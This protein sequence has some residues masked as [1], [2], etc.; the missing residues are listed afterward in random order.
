MSDLTAS[1]LLLILVGAFGWAIFRV[2]TTLE[3]G[4]PSSKRADY[5]SLGG[6]APEDDR[7]LQE[8]I[9]V[10]ARYASTDDLK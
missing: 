7:V 5:A 1:L 3:A 9:A 6:S 2:V 10:N 4:G 8:A